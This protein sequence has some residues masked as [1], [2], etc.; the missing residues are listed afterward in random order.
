MKNHR[1]KKIIG[2]DDDLYGAGPSNWK[3]TLGDML[4]GLLAMIIYG[5][6]ILI[7]ILGACAKPLPE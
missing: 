4:V 5:G 3:P 7:I 1:K 6:I 2:F